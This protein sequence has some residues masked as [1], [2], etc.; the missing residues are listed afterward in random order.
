M[1]WQV[2]GY[3]FTNVAHRGSPSRKG[4]PWPPNAYRS[5]KTNRPR[6]EAPSRNVMESKHTEATRSKGCGL[7]LRRGVSFYVTVGTTDWQK[8]YPL[9]CKL[10][11]YDH[12]SQRPDISTRPLYIQNQQIQNRRLHRLQYLTRGQNPM[13]LSSNNAH[14]L[15]YG[16]RTFSL[17]EYV[18]S[19]RQQTFTTST[20][21]QEFLKILSLWK[22]FFGADMLRI[23]ITSQQA[24]KIVLTSFTWFYPKKCFFFCWKSKSASQGAL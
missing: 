10:P 9:K 17:R 14:Q 7:T 22:W 19:W 15:D 18:S 11:H 16:W 3:D 13:C 23:T 5:L 6:R 1:T 12:E 21:K 2:S 24:R 20:S 4:I 8:N